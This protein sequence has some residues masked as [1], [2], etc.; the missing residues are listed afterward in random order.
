MPG[1][2]S[3]SSTFSLRSKRGFF[4]SGSI[5]VNAR[6]VRPRNVSVRFSALGAKDDVVA[7]RSDGTNES[8]PFALSGVGEALSA[9]SP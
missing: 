9:I 7:F 5:M 8:L 1:R 2:Y 3:E 6:F 4:D